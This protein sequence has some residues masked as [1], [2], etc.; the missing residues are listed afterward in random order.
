MPLPCSA[1]PRNTGTDLSSLHFLRQII[2][3][4]VTR[5]LHV[6]QQ[7]LHEV[8]I[9]VGQLLEHVEAC[10]LLAVEHAIGHLDDL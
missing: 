9:I 10:G 8:I 2:E 5:R 4:A 1:E 7:L 3:D 6:G